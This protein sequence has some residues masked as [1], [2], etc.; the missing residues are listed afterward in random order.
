MLARMRR[1]ARRIAELRS[2][3]VIGASFRI[4]CFT[5]TVRITLSETR[6]L[7]C[8]PTGDRLVARLPPLRA[9]HRWALKSLLESLALWSGQREERRSKALYEAEQGSREYEGEG[10]SAAFPLPV[11]FG[12]H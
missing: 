2:A 3:T 8:D 11:D 6:I 10:K 4:Q 1:E 7:V 5:A 12:A 9:S